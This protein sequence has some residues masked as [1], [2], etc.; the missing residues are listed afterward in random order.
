L[1]GLSMSGNAAP[2]MPATTAARRSA[3]VRAA[4]APIA[5]RL[6]SPSG[7]ATFRKCRM[8]AQSPQCGTASSA[9]WETTPAAKAVA[10]RRATAPIS[11]PDRTWLVSSTRLTVRDQRR[12]DYPGRPGGHCW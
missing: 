6:I 2:A 5:A 10:G 7:T 3:G 8:L 11:A 4:K 1:A 12:R 9:K